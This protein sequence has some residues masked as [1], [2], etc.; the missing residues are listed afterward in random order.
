MG[1]LSRRLPPHW[2]LAGPGKAR[3][4]EPLLRGRQDVQGG[5]VATLRRL[6]RIGPF[7][8][9]LL[10]IRRGRVDGGTP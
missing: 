10:R 6:L 3:D 8:V 7:Q 4:A 5:H 9:S 2:A 1:A